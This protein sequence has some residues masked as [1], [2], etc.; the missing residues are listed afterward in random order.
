MLTMRTAM[1]AHSHSCL[2]PASLVLCTAHQSHAP[3]L[4]LTSY[5]ASK[6]SPIPS[7]PS[8][9]SPV[10][11]AG[12]SIRTRLELLLVR[13][14]LTPSAHLECACESVIGPCWMLSILSSFCYRFWLR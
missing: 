8:V 4:P 1:E 14:E 5:A 7:L 9:I 11:R 13:M 2:G 6:S 12:R 10:A 3:S